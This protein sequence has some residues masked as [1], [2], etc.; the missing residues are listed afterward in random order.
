MKQAGNAAWRALSN[1]PRDNTLDP[2]S[3]GRRK[4][5]WV[6]VAS[7]AELTEDR[8]GHVSSYR[9]LIARRVADSSTEDDTIRSVLA[10]FWAVVK[11]ET[12]KRTGPCQHRN[13][14]QDLSEINAERMP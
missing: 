7:Q 1:E 9:Q 11:C 14:A 3:E 12:C 4:R 10:S 5:G 8:R 2:P 13:K 6:T